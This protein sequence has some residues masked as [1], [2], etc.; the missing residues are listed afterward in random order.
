MIPAYNI[1]AAAYCL[2]GKEDER[3]IDSA[4]RKCKKQGVYAV[5]NAAVARDDVA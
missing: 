2:S 5:E 1:Y 4:G 3:E